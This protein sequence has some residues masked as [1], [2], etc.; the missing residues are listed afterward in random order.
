MGGS[1]SK[2][3]PDAAEE[4]AGDYSNR[5]WLIYKIKQKKVQLVTL[6]LFIDFQKAGKLPAQV[7][8]R[9]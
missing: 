5:E 3:A 7:S 8:G 9:A 6:Q 2:R 1:A 4:V